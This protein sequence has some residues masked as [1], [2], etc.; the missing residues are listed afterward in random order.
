VDALA[1]RDAAATAMTAESR[2]RRQQCE[3]LV[4]KADQLARKGRFDEA[5][6]ALEQASA[7]EPDA[8]IVSE[9]AARVH[10]ARLDAERASE[11]ERR[12]AA[13]IAT[14]R[15][16]FNLGHRD[17]AI[18][19]LRALLAEDPEAPG[20]GVALNDLSALAERLRAAEQR[21]AQAAE[22]AKAAEAA[23]TADD[24]EKA[25]SLSREALLLAGDDEL[26][27]KIQGL[28]TARLRE[29]KAA[30]ERQEQIA[31]LLQRARMLLERK[32]Y[33]SARDS[34]RSAAALS[35][36]DDQIKALLT[37]IDDAE[38]QANEE[39]RLE[40]EA[41]QRNKAAAPVL[42]L[43]KSAEAAQDLARAAWL[44]EN[45]LALDPGCAEAQEIV[46][47]AQARLSAQPELADETVNM[48]GGAR[49][50]ADVD[51]TVTLVP[52]EPAW[53][54]L[55]GLVRS[56]VHSGHREGA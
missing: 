16:A 20:A 46:Q 45:A 5:D 14:A 19:D 39:E 23:L 15:A 32:K 30:R 36:S 47:R 2:R 3:Q 11:R 43:A 21:R 31:Q 4:A 51:D 56:W 50:P 52:E 13:A 29:L 22:Q 8:R 18:A 9:M 7:F 35:P 24:P 27:K 54:K 17:Q 10:A 55:A 53:R 28:A 6:Q 41:R 38:A 44:A 25:L 40:R 26:A 1:L 33:G 48:A 34:A 42:A 12:A 37:T 49:R